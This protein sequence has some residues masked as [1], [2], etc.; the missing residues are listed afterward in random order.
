MPKSEQASRA[1]IQRNLQGI[2]QE[3]AKALLEMKDS[4]YQGV[5]WRCLGIKQWAEAVLQR[6]SEIQS[7]IQEKSLQELRKAGW[8]IEEQSL[9]KLSPANRNR[10][11]DLAAMMG[12]TPG[13]AWEG[14]LRMAGEEN[15]EPSEALELMREGALKQLLEAT[16][17]GRS[18]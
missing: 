15:I 18:S 8:D 1:E 2:K 14:V 13:Q 12:V 7:E 10:V 3:A 6:L 4:D 17:K 9:D 11:G 16:H 5:T